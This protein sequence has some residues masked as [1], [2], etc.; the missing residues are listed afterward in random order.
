[1]SNTATVHVLDLR[2]KGDRDYLHGTDIIPALLQLAGPLQKL[3][4]QIHRKTSNELSAQWVDELKL[5][6][7]RKAGDICVLMSYEMLDGCKKYIVVTEDLS[8]P[9]KDSQPYD[10][11]KV[12][13]AASIQKQTITQELYAAGTLIERMVALNKSLLTQL[14]GHSSWL[15]CG[16][17]LKNLPDETAPLAISLKNKFG[18]G[19]YKSVIVTNGEE[20]G[21]LTFVENV[22]A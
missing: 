7:M 5:S 11:Q 6:Q 20:L 12:V 2:F 19:L 13:N 15:F 4:V 8:T 17:E 21:S 22:T 18:R 10:E 9:V 16:L 1:M 3:S 14:E